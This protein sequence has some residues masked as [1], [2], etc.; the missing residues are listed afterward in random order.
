MVDDL[1][2]FIDGPGYLLL[3]GFVSGRRLLFWSKP[4]CRAQAG[5]AWGPM[6]APSTPRAARLLPPIAQAHRSRCLQG[7]SPVREHAGRSIP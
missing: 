5:R 3:L 6:A 4:S 7:N 1:C 2:L